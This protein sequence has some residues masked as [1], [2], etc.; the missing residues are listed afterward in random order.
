MTSEEMSD[1]FDN[2]DDEFLN[3]NA[4]ESRLSN[5][6]DLHA[7]LL[8]DELIPGESDLVGSADYDEIWLDVD[9]EKFLEV[10]TEEHI[11][12]LSRCGVRYDEEVDSLCMFV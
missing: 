6:P 9:M 11:T 1:L 4:V 2:S 10:A 5:R 8:L 7:F 3:F 12:E